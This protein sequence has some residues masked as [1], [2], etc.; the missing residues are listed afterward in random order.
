MYTCSLGSL[1][2][3]EG[4]SDSS[5]VGLY[6]G[7]VFNF[8]VNEISQ[9]PNDFYTL[10]RWVSYHLVYYFSFFTLFLKIFLVVSLIVAHILVALL[11]PV[12]L[13]LY[14]FPKVPQS[15]LNQR[16]SICSHSQLSSSFNHSVSFLFCFG[17]TSIISFTPSDPS[18]EPHPPLRSWHPW[19][20]LALWWVF[21]MPKLLR[22]PPKN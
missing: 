6:F 21:H 17:S 5:W 16:A 22:V 4:D 9:V 14:P 1:I 12:S 15:S 8:W 18:L 11:L 2:C 13:V 20:Y 7:Y 10:Q 3:T 19:G